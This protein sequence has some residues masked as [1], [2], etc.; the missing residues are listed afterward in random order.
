MTFFVPNRSRW[1]ITSAFMLLAASTDFGAETGKW[2]SLFNGKS[3]A[4][5][6]PMG[7]HARYEVRDGAIVG[8][9]V[10]DKFGSFLVTEGAYSD[11]VLE[12]EFKSDWGPNSGVQ[13]RASTP[14]GY[15][16]A[17]MLGYQ[18][19]IDPTDRGITGALNADIPGK[20]GHGLS[21][22]TH[23]GAPRD[24]WVKERADGKWL[25]RDTW[26]AFR[27]ECRGAH[28][29]LWLNEH[30]TVEFDDPSFSRGFIGLQ[31]TQAPEKSP[32]IGKSIA[33]RNLRL[34]EL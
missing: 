30:L 6:K 20:K 33:F 31:V 32:L 7:G 8:T 27:I 14:P 15:P 24:A 5:W 13:F 22:E 21:P 18:Y 12:G 1:L 34:R 3:L 26:N 16:E 11:F 17:R 10:A 23:G 9:V 25:K 29:R 4:G 19:E 2:I 28:I